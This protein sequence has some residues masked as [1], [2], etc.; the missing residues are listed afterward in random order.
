MSGFIRLLKYDNFYLVQE[1][2]EK[3]ELILRLFPAKDA[4][5]KFIESRMVIYEQMWDGCGC[6]VD[7]YS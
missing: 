5:D 3:E 7:Y 4:A 1:I 6:K 2:T